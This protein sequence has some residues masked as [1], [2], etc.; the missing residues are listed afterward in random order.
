MQADH[1]VVVPHF[2]VSLAP[3]KLKKSRLWH[4][5]RGAERTALETLLQQYEAENPGV[6][7]NPR[8]IP[9]DGFNSKLEAAVPGDTDPICL[10]PP[11]SGWAPGSPW[12]G[13]SKSEALTDVPE[14]VEQALFHEGTAVRFAARLQDTGLFYNRARIDTPPSTTDEMIEIALP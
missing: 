8:A 11:T 2:L 7:V 14:T 6:S 1:A 9:Y 10:S 13:R 3:P 4:A 5:Y 12:V